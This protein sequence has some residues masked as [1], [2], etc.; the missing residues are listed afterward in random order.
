M[1]VSG[2]VGVAGISRLIL[3]ESA[4]LEEMLW[5]LGFL[6]LLIIQTEI[7]GAVAAVAA[8]EQVP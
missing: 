4:K 5:N 8:V 2:L 1:A 7:F 3:R 6:L